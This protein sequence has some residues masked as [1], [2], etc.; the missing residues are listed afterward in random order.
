MSIDADHLRQHYASLS[1]EELIALDRNDL[2]DTA[3]QYY[4]EEMEQRGISVEPSDTG[5]DDSDETTTWEHGTMGEEEGDDDG[6]I[7]CTF[8]DHRGVSSVGEAEEAYKALRSAGIPC[9][10]E[11]QTIESEPV[12]AESRTEHQV[13]VPSGFSLQA[14]SVLDKEVFNPRMESDWKTHLESLTDEQLLRLNAD[15]ICAGLLDRA[16]RLRKAY[17]EEVRR[18]SATSSSR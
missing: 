1:D 3:Q 14:T 2:T 5:D 13:I 7:A 12:P 15:V 16:A 17:A 10:V 6:F 9:R 11:T 8:T 4:D 18:R